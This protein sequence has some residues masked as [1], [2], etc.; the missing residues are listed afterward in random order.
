MCRVLPRCR[1]G[2]QPWLLQPLYDL[3]Q[4]QNYCQRSWRFDNLLSAHVFSRVVFSQPSSVISRRSLAAYLFDEILLT[5]TPA[6]YKER[7]P[8]CRI[9]NR[10][11]AHR[12]ENPRN[13]KIYSKRF[14]LPL[15]LLLLWTIADGSTKHHTNN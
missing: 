6:G 13:S 3:P 11:T 9:V 7:K 12:D 14:P 10:V 1:L 15:A 4:R 5:V 2:I 8:D